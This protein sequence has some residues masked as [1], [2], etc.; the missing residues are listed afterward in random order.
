MERLCTLCTRRVIVAKGLCSCC[1]NNQAYAKNPERKRQ[2]KRDWVSKNKERVKSLKRQS[3]LLRNYG[4]T[5]EDYDRILQSQ[6]GNCATCGRTDSGRPK[7]PRLVVDHN[8]KTGKVR[9]LLCSLCNVAIGMIQESP[10]RLERIK[11]YLT[12]K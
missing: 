2:L 4:I 10:E 7:N 11:T 9:G 6:A 3:A 8:H 1:Y 12:E 5:T